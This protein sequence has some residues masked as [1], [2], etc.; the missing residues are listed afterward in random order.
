MVDTNNP[1]QHLQFNGLIDLPFGRGK[2]W[3][4]NTSKVLNEV[5]GGWQIAG[6]GR[7]IVTDFQITSTNFGSTNPLKVY[8]HGAPVTDCRSG[9][10]LK[11]YEWFNGYLAPTVLP[12]SNGGC[13]TTSTTVQGLPGNWAPYQQPIDVKCGDKYYGDNDVA[14]TGVINSTTGVAQPA[15]TVL[16]YGVVPSNNNN[17]ASEGA[18]D[19]T[20]PY[21]HTVLNGPMNW[22]ADASLFKLFPIT[23]GVILRIN[24]D[25]FNV[26]NN[27]GLPNPS[28]TDGTVCVTPGGAG[29][30]S[31]NTPRQLQFSARLSF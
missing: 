4:G 19:V 8:K 6:A 5:V 21:G 17:G 23:E 26:F 27:Q 28:G 14:M 3:L 2:R 25:A 20:N 9:V 15:G 18:I 12:S 13:A 31:Y 29:C 16:A 7:F 10:C 1:P 24:L 30:S 11:S 22:S